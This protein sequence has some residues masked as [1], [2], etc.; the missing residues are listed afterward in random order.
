MSVAHGKKLFT[1]L[2]QPLLAHV[3]EH[4]AVVVVTRVTVGAQVVAPAHAGADAPVVVVV[5]ALVAL[6]VVVLDVLADA[7][8]VA[9]V[10]VMDALDVVLGARHPVIRAAQVVVVA[11]AVLEHVHHVSMDAQMHV[12]RVALAVLKVILGDQV[13]L[14]VVLHV[15]QVAMDVQTRAPDRKVHRRE[16]QQTA[17]P[18]HITG[19]IQEP[20][21]VH[22]ISM[23]VELLVPLRLHMARQ[24]LQYQK[25]VS[26]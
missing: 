10:I 3:V 23:V 26:D 20:N 8:V 24:L 11:L 15:I 16:G 22:H 13:A 12:Y 21:M 2:L 6:E 18:I 14:A 17:L 25:M 19:L 9:L 5:V 4:V 7:R 1:K